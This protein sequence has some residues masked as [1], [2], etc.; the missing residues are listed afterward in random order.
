MQWDL[1][2]GVRI[3]S[4]WFQNTSRVTRSNSRFVREDLAITPQPTPVPDDEKL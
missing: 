2:A 3:E 1:L 4:S